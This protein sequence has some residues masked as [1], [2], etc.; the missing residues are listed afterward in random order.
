MFLRQVKIKFLL[1]SCF[2]NIFKYFLILRAEF[3]AS[4]DS[5]S[6]EEAPSIM[7]EDEWTD[8]NFGNSLLIEEEENENTSEDSVSD[9]DSDAGDSDDERLVPFHYPYSGDLESELVWYLNGPK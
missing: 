5:H 2:V 3:E 6:E 9:L 8:R 1:Y 7:D 4:V